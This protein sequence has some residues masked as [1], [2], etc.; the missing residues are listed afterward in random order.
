MSALGYIYIITNKINNKQYI[1]QTSRSIEVRYNEHCYD[2]RS[3]SAIHKAIKEYGVSNFEVK[4]LE[5]VPLEKLDERE[6]YWVDYYDT[7]NNGYNLT[8][9]GQ[10]TGRTGYSQL[11]V[12]ENGFIFDSRSALAREMKRIAS[13]GEKTVIEQIGKVIDTDKTFCDYHFRSC[14]ASIEELTDIVDVENWIKTLNVRFQGTR[15]LCEE[16]DKEF[17]SIGLAAKWLFD[18][19]YYQGT[20]RMPIQSIITSI[21]KHLHGETECVDS[22][23]GLHFISLPGKP[24]T[25]GSNKPCQPSPVYCP[26]LDKT[27][28]SQE[29]AAKYMIDNNIWKVKL[30]TAKLRISDVVRGVYPDYKGY[31]FIK[32]GDTNEEQKTDT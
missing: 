9:G 19:G 26:Q 5:K 22:V 1:G 14:S 31:T 27:F 12:V 15:L 3:N 24:H 6:I 8:K 17:E 28:E 16:L 7:F 25:S 32:K 2:N 18:N 10:N 11:M 23:G 21:G 20:A 29:K 4:E 30:K 13:W